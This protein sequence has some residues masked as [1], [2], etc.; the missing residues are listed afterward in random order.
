MQNIRLWIK[1]YL[2]IATTGAQN[3]NVY[4]EGN[5]HKDSWR[6]PQPRLHSLLNIQE[7]IDFPSLASYLVYMTYAP[8][9]EGVWRR[10]SKSLLGTQSPVLCREGYHSRTCLHCLYT[11]L[12]AQPYVFAA[13]NDSKQQVKG[14]WEASES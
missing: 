5:W 12:Q 4:S 9:P 11:V 3:L 10:P 14:E 6:D 7:G 1:T 13:Y 8:K 2:I